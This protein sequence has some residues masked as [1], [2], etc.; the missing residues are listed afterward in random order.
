[1]DNLFLKYAKFSI[2]VNLTEFPISNT[3]TGGR[4]GGG[5]KSFSVNN[6]YNYL[7]NDS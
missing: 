6:H 3:L 1:M 4:G 5:P 7:R 2:N